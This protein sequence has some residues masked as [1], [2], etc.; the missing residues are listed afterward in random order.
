MHQS[1]CQRPDERS[2]WNVSPQVQVRV[3]DCREMAYFPWQQSGQARALLGLR[4]WK[5]APQD[6]HS[7]SARG[8]S[9]FRLGR[10]SRHSIEQYLWVFWRGSKSVPQIVQG[11][12]MGAPL[13]WLITGS[14]VAHDGWLTTGSRWLKSTI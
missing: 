13:G 7:L 1:H 11:L 5:V 14:R 12:L 10:L 4:V 8:R 2:V 9:P 6:S 3:S